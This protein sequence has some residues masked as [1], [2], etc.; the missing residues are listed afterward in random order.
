MQQ[1]TDTGIVLSA[2]KYGEQSAVVR[3]LTAEH[4]VYAGMV[5]GAFSKKSRGIYQAGN[6]VHI[7]WQARLEEHLGQMRCELTQS[8]TDRLL[9]NPLALAVMNATTGV[10]LTCVPERIEEIKIYNF[11]KSIIDNIK[12]S[13]ES[14]MLHAYVLAEFTILHAL[15]FGLDLSCCA[16]NGTRDPEALIYVSPKSGKAVSREAGEPYK[17]KMLPLPE[18]LKE[19]GAHKIAPTMR[20]MLDGLTLTG[21][22]LDAWVLR[23]EGK[24]LPEAR[25]YLVEMLKKL[26]ER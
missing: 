1:W 23:P 14:N 10:L 9:E 13:D 11:I 3:L 21:Y 19:G 15:G 12:L 17:A 4:G 18:F 5:K 20:Q 26:A 8:I 24:Q 7:H 25:V 6:V 16:G 2:S 22:F